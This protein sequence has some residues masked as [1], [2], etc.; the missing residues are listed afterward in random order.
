MGFEVTDSNP[1]SDLKSVASTSS[2]ATTILDIEN[3]Q[4]GK[5]MDDPFL[6]D[7][8]KLIKPNPISTEEDIKF[9]CSLKYF[10]IR[11]KEEWI[12]FQRKIPFIIIYIFALAYVYPVLMRNVGFY[13]HHTMKDYIYSNG[14]VKQKS[15]YDLGHELLPDLSQ[16]TKTSRIFLQLNEIIQYFLVFSLISVILSILF[17]KRSKLGLRSRKHGEIANLTNISA[18]GI[19]FRYMT[20]MVLGHLLRS[21]TYPLTSLPGPAKHCTNYTI[22][23]QNR[24]ISFNQIFQLRNSPLE[25]CG[26]LLFSGHMV[27]AS[28]VVYCITYYLFV[29]I[30][31]NKRK[32]V[33][34]SVIAYVIFIWICLACQIFT[35][36]ATRNHYTVDIWLGGLIGYMNWMWHRFVVIPK[37]PVVGKSDRFHG[38]KIY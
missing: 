30:S 38:V 5:T 4:Y 28:C 31:T 9:G 32:F 1:I 24:P 33:R 8:D 36:I 22:E 16:D 18:I 6:K 20:M 29:M 27:S 17:L 15:L 26:D 3:V 35:A 34:F 7:G 25:N 37:D 21:L 19:L 10:K 14:T 12:L 2:I 13:L 23:A 11:A